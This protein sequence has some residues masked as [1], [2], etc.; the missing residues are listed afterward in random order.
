MLS[1]DF[2]NEI[3]LVP[4]Q[5]EIMF[6]K[7]FLNN[8]PDFND[9]DAVLTCVSNMNS[10]TQLEYSDFNYKISSKDCIQVAKDIYFE[11]KE[12]HKLDKTDKISRI[13]FRI[14]TDELKLKDL[15]EY[16]QK[17]REEYEAQKNNKLGNEVFFFDQIT[18][19]DS[20]FQNYLSFDKKRFMTSRTFDNVFFEERNDVANRVNHFMNNKQWYDKRGIPHT[21]GFLFH[22][23]PGT[24]KCLDPDTPVMVWPGQ[25]KLAR[26]IVSSDLLVDDEC[27]PVSIT[28][29]AHGQD[30]MYKVSY[31]HRTGS[32]IVNSEHIL[33]VVL[34]KTFTILR[35]TSGQ[36]I[37]IWYEW[38]KKKTNLVHHREY[39]NNYTDVQTRCAQIMLTVSPHVAIK[40]DTLDINVVKYMQQPKSF[41]KYWQGYKPQH[42]SGWLNS[43]DLAD[44]TNILNSEGRLDSNTRRIV[45][46]IKREFWAASMGF[47]I[48]YLSKNEIS[49]AG[50]QLWSFLPHKWIGKVDTRWMENCYPIT[51]SKVGWGP[52][53]GFTLPN[54]HPTSRF[55]LGDFTV[56]HNT[57][58]IKAIANITHR[59]IINVRLSEIKTNTQLK[60]L[61]F[62]PVLQVEN[63][64]TLTV[65]KF[66]VPIHQRFYVIEDI[67]C[68][69]D[70]IK[71]REFKNQELLATN[72]SNSNITGN[73]KDTSK[74]SSNTS[75]AGTSGT[76]KKSSDQ[77]I[78]THSIKSLYT[79]DDDAD[80]YE[81]EN[82][83]QTALAQEKKDMEDEQREDEERDKITLDSL[84][85]ILDGTLEIPNRMFCVTTNHIEVID[86]ALIRPGRVDMIIEFKFCTKAI[87]QE[88]FESFYEQSF[89]A[90]K[91][92]KITDYKISP[93]VVN[94]YLFKN[95]TKPDNAIEELI[96]LSNKK[97]PYNKTKKSNNTQP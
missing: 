13:K 74:S 68:M 50:N 19:R 92:A 88:M 16:V 35:E 41:K 14:Y 36:Y 42:T 76:N 65:E 71:K 23:P 83:Y 37:L 64:E 6:E 33:S 67:D 86:P 80:L 84:L 69:G 29:I 18:T 43:L 20:K 27:K 32:Y 11:L 59:H 49:I 34:N 40:G 87:I 44:I 78:Q 24:G 77:P 61:F 51:V 72:A 31:P 90:S 62:N 63:P 12:I 85:N 95:M 73:K 39:F 97:G 70:L 52:Y 55:L 57:S 54:W 26:D 89:E 21:I 3:P 8:Q 17:C 5:C 48:K 2:D 45:M 4:V 81:L 28:G 1:N 22:G 58:T 60:N 30:N 38:R 46:P 94:Q 25:I 66:T 79:E 15:K 82:Y 56:T 7:N 53:V 91:F 75:N 96:V 47:N 9:F 10:I 93:A